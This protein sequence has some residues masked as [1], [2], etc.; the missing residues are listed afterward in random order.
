MVYQYVRENY[1]GLT[2]IQVNPM[3]KKIY[4]YVMMSIGSNGCFVTNA[5]CLNWGLKNKETSNL[6]MCVC[7]V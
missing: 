5:P 7:N 3:V 1:H 4:D 6:T 2:I